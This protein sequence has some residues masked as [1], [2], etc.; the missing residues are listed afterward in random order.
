MNYC[1][2]YLKLKFFLLV[3]EDILFSFVTFKGF[4]TLAISLKRLKI[5]TK[6]KFYYYF[7]SL[8]V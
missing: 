8:F 1:C 2:R 3:L 6:I 4:N 5:Y 7:I